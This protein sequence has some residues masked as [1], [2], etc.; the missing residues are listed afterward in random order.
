MVEQQ[1]LRKNKAMLQLVGL[2]NM[3]YLFKHVGK[4]AEEDTYERALEK[5]RAGIT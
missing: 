1:L 3:T 2:L 5:I 4:L